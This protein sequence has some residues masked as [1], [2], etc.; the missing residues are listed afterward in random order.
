MKKD[1]IDKLRCFVRLLWWLGGEKGL[2]LCQLFFCTGPPSL[3]VD[4]CQHNLTEHYEPVSTYLTLL[5]KF[6]A[7]LNTKPA[8]RYKQHRASQRSYL[9]LYKFSHATT[10]LAILATSC[11]CDWLPLRCIVKVSLYQLR[12]VESCTEKRAVNSLSP[13]ILQF[14]LQCFICRVELLCI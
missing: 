5:E 2:V 9:S 13:S 10:G 3:N 8:I 14:V 6:T 1:Y 11:T 7:L 12:S 4:W